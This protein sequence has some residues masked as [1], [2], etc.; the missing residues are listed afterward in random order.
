M[1]R[2]CEWCRQAIT[3]LDAQTSSGNAAWHTRCWNEAEAE[4]AAL[5]AEF[6]DT[7]GFSIHCLPDELSLSET[8]SGRR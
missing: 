5:C 7:E 1:P 8:V 6:D 3:L 2:I 4:Q